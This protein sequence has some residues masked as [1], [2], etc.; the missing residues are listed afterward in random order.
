MN[1]LV[2]YFRNVLH[3]NFESQLKDI[4]LRKLSVI[5]TTVHESYLN[6]PALKEAVNLERFLEGVKT[7]LEQYDRI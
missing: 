4:S 7:K 1:E 6:V 5:R 3:Y 2:K